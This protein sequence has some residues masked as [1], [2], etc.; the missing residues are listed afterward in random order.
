MNLLKFTKNIDNIFYEFI[1]IY[2]KLKN[3][4]I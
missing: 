3:N 4:I 2:E 1:K